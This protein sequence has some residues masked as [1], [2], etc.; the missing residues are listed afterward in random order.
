MEA[1]GATRLSE[2]MKGDEITGNEVPFKV[3]VSINS[4]L[5]RSYIIIYI[6]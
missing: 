3:Y 5:N 1:I 2:F 6:Y 4:F